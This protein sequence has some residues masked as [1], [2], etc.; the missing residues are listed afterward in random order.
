MRSPSDFGV[1]V[2]EVK[3]QRLALVKDLSLQFCKLRTQDGKKCR[4]LHCSPW[5]SG[6]FTSIFPR[7]R[8]IGVKET[9]PATAAFSENSMSSYPSNIR[10][11]SKRAPPFRHLDDLCSVDAIVNLAPTSPVIALAGLALFSAFWLPAKNSTEICQIGNF[12][13]KTRKRP[14]LERRT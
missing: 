9:C 11:I 3:A 12:R 8:A 5:G 14:H 7:R 6:V 10:P 13:S 2:Y 4:R 1:S